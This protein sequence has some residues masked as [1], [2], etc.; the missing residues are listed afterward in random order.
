MTVI[1]FAAFLICS[2][3]NLTTANRHPV[4]KTFGIAG[5]NLP[6]P[7]G[8]SKGMDVT[9]QAVFD[10]FLDSMQS[11]LDAVCIGQPQA[12]LDKRIKI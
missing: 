10:D 2:F 11:D 6:I 5:V 1:V 7:K 8:G 12:V 9:E 4:Q 3:S